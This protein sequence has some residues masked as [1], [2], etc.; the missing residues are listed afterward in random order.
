M[1]ERLAPPSDDYSVESRYPILVIKTYS[2]AIF[3]LFDFFYFINI[4]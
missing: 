3:F 1:E 2:L 4:R